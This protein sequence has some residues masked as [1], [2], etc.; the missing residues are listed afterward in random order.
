MTLIQNIIQ[1]ILN[2]GAYQ[3]IMSNPHIE[4]T[5]IEDWVNQEAD[6]YRRE[7]RKAVHTILHAIAKS[8][9]LSSQMIMKGEGK[10]FQTMSLKVG[11]APERF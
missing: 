1:I 10:S 2:A 3:L 9:Q 4:T 5:N 6:P 7:L 11:Y 8:Q